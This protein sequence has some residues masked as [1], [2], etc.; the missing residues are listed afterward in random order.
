MGSHS[1]LCDL[2]ISSGSLLV[3]ITLSSSLMIVIGLFV[4]L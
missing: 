3:F 1:F 4:S 2:L